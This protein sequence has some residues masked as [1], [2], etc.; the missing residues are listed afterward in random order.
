MPGVCV[1]G[2]GEGEG[3]GSVR[4]LPSSPHEPMEEMITSVGS[5]AGRQKINYI[6][7]AR[8][9]QQKIQMFRRL[10]KKQWN[11]I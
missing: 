6:S 8:S 3:V 2:G 1:C 9:D 10:F 5:Q 4:V 7:L 11:L